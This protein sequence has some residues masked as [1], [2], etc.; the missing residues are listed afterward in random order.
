MVS[1]DEVSEDKKMLLQ[2]MHTRRRGTTLQMP[3]WACETGFDLYTS[4]LQAFGSKKWIK[5]VIVT[6]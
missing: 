2:K 4:R 1:C 6:V 3:P 5:N